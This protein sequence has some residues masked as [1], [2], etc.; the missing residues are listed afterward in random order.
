MLLRE[1]RAVKEMRR[2]SFI[3]ELGSDRRGQLEGW[4]S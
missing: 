4:F 1:E 2:R 3:M